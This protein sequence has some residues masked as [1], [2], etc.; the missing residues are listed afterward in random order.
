MIID[1][2]AVAHAANTSIRYCS[3]LRDTLDN[4]RSRPVDLGQPAH[5]VGQVDGRE[6]CNSMLRTT[7]TL[8]PF[9]VA[10]PMLGHAVYPC[11][12]AHCQ[13]E[14]ADSAPT[15]AHRAA[16]RAGLRHEA[17]SVEQFQ[18]GFAAIMRCRR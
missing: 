15:P 7:E 6:A 16:S 11:A 5:G 2:E 17:M 8:Q 10:K 13:P 3:I 18:I 14:Y 9:S 1:G 4:P 12:V